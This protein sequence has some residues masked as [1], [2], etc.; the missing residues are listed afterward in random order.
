[1]PEPSSRSHSNS[2]RRGLHRRTDT[3]AKSDEAFVKFPLGRRSKALKLSSIYQN[4]GEN[5]P[6]SFSLILSSG[7]RQSKC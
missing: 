2:D 4:L 7:H 6:F 1:M 5:R 3:S